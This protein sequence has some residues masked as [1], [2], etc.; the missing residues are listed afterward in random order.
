M[1]ADLGVCQLREI[2]PEDA[3]W[4]GP[5]LAAR[6]PWLTLGYAAAPLTTYLDRGDPCLARLTVWV[7]GERAGVVALR[8]PWLR[9][10][11]LELLA[12]TRPGQGLG[13]AVV[14]WLARRST[15]NLWT[16]CTSFNTAA[17]RFYERQGF[18]EAA[19]IPD[20]IKPG[21]DEVLMRMRR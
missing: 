16:S 8:Y 17:R 12:I 7:G 18:V 14:A 20:L 13:T 2:T 9:G 4:A 15:D 21:F 3:A 19:V 10:P 6:E 11:F 5:E 1:I